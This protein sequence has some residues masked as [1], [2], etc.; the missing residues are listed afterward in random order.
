MRSLQELI[1]QAE[2]QRAPADAARAARRATLPLRYWHQ[3]AQLT[4]PAADATR[5]SKA[6]EAGTAPMSR[7]LARWQISAEALAERLA[8]PVP[9]VEAALVRPRRAPL[10]V[11]DGEDALA[12]RAD[13]RAQGRETAVR[14]LHEADWATATLRFYRPPGL[15][16]VGAAQDLLT[17]LLGA[18]QGRDPRAYPLD[19]IV[20]PKVEQP[21]EIDWIMATLDEVERSLRLEPGRIRLALLIESGWAMAQLPALIQRA[22]PRLCALILGLADY[23]ADL[24]L[25]RIA[26][27]DLLADWARVQVINAAGAVGVPAIDGMTLA[28]PVADPAADPAANRE[29]FLSRM[30]LV[31]QDAC[32]ARAL[33]MAGKWVGH[34]AQLFAVLLAFE[35]DLADEDLERE[36]RHLHAYTASVQDQA[37]G[38]TVIEGAM[39]DRAT[40]RHARM[41][42]RRAVTL[43]RLDP[44]RALQLGIIEPRELP[45]AQ[46]IWNS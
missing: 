19:G 29:R 28:Y 46:A 8:L 43:G 17:V 25:P 14:V 18:G 15:D 44:L 26:D 41:R 22:A 5:A 33:G 12:D 40:D 3:H 9:T 27:R 7:L 34:P 2:R 45:A 1:E 37:Q 42:L 30:A 35:Q 6:V 23:S 21:E 32:H 16:H 4:T 10:V 24:A 39:A 38:V 20:F 13:V 11:L 31:Y 36:I